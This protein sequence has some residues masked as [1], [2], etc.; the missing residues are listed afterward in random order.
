MDYLY[1][2]NARKNNQDKFYLLKL[3]PAKLTL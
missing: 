3:S 2:R 1:L